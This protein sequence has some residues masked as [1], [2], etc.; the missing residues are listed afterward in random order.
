MENKN[1]KQFVV[2]SDYDLNIFESRVNDYLEKV[3]YTL[4]NIVIAPNGRFV[5]AMQKYGI[6]TC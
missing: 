1:E 4:G 6:C 5:L 3:Y 2:V